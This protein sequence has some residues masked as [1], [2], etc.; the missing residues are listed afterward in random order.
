[1]LLSGGIDSA[2]CARLLLDEG[3]TVSCVFIDYGQ[4]A[5]ES[6]SAASIA[7]NLRCSL[8][9]IAVTPRHHFGAGEITGRIAFLVLAALTL[10]EVRSG[11]IALGIHSGTPYYPNRR[12]AHRP[13]LVLKCR[14]LL[15]GHDCH[16]RE[17]ADGLPAGILRHAVELCSEFFH[18]RIFA[19]NFTRLLTVQSDL[20][21]DGATE[22]ALIDIAERSG[23]ESP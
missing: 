13:R 5:A 3:N 4:A 9:K 1:V 10:C 16:W 22:N 8:L 19:G 12:V 23:H 20:R 11:V 18:C 15:A 2:A 14:R 6:R 7:T 21:G 17:H